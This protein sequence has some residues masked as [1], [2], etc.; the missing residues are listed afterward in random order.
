MYIVRSSQV[1]NKRSEDAIRATHFR[2]I[3]HFSLAPELI[4]P[5]TSA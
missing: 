1:K 3:F 2:N 4:C 5:D